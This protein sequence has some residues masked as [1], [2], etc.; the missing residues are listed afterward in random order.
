M[1]SL[2]EMPQ[3]AFAPRPDPGRL[4]KRYAVNAMRHAALP[5]LVFALVFTM[6]QVSEALRVPIAFCLFHSLLAIPCPGCGVTTSVAA[7]LRGSV[8]AA[9]HA[10][11]AGPFVLLF[12]VVQLFLTAAAISRY[13]PEQRVIAVTNLN[14]RILLVVLIV[15]WTIRLF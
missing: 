10:N 15:C 14:D 12:A 7:L 2:S 1:V 9:L 11:T 4:E 3:V 13:L 6:A 5:L 8:P